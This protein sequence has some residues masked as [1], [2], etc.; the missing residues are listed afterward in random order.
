MPKA[1]R[2][3]VVVVGG[4]A[5]GAAIARILSAKI[6]PNTAHLTL[7]TARPF[8]LH[9][10]AAIRMTT[11][12]EGNLEDDVLIPYD[13]LLVNNNGTIKVGLVTSI[14][15]S[16]EGKSAGGSVVL[17]TNEHIHYDILVLAPGS[18]WSGPLAFPDD[19]AA[20]LQHIKSWRRKFKNSSGIVLVGG[21]AVGCGTS[22]FCF[23]C[24]SNQP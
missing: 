20:V 23:I 4:G 2:K 7:I 8:A 14:E 15:R 18:E 10:P 22:L 13:N 21:G 19:R 5:A 16:K 9:L 11:T 24:L 12:A 17:S 6:K 3:S 1:S